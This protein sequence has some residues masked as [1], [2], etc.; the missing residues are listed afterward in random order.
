VTPEQTAAAAHPAVREFGNSFAEDPRTLRRA[1]QLGLTGWAFYI[2]G[3]AGVLGDVDPDTVAAALGF[4]AADAVRDGWEA[5]RRVVPPR[6]IAE[7]HLAECCRWGREKLDDLPGATRLVALAGRVVAAAEPGGLPLFA[8]WR[9]MPVPEDGPGA[10]VAVLARLLGEHRASA[11]L[12]AVR[13]AGLTPL[14]AVLASAGGP[15]E[16]VA[17]GWQP[18]FPPCG[19]LLRKRVWADALTERITGEA[20]RTLS[21]PERAE[22]VELLRDAA[23]ALR[24]P[25]G[26]YPRVRQA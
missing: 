21:V 17:F 13:A 7:H 22:L 14:E 4:V 11:R 19:P 2:A 3:R 9:A 12:V 6:Q 16:A 15:A 26:E 8:A 10:R 5:G 20:Y 18:P 1:R 25:T 23:R 24:I